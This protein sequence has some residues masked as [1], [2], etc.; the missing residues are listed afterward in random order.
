MHKEQAPNETPRARLPVFKLFGRRVAID[1]AHLAFVTAIAAWCL[2]YGLDAYAAQQT[3][4]NLIFIAP[5]TVLALVFYLVIAASCFHVIGRE[6]QAPECERPPMEKGK[7]RLI[8]IAIAMLIA[9]VII[10]PTIGFD[11]AVF[12]YVGGMLFFLG[13]RRIWNLILTPLIFYLIAIYCFNQIL[14]APLPLFFFGG[15]A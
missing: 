7:P 15:D 2:W 12:V 6:E 13:E 3:L 14:Y 10:G 1:A 9:F 8:A 5:A 4:P 11:V